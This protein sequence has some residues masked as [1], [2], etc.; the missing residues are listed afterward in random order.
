METQIEPTPKKNQENIKEPNKENNL[1][2]FLKT[3]I[4][5]FHN[6][7]ITLTLIILIYHMHFH[8]NSNHINKFIYLFLL[9][10]IAKP[11]SISSLIKSHT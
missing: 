9:A 6:I 3:K 7:I 11:K 4:F 8:C 2:Y 5:T 1:V 10:V